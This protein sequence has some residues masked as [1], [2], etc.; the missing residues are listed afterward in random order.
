MEFL[1]LEI[2]SWADIAAA[3]GTIGAVWI[4]LLLSRADR[5]LH[6]EDKQIEDLNVMY[7]LIL[8]MN[9]LSDLI[10]QAKAHFEF[11]DS[12]GMGTTSSNDKA[13]LHLMRRI[14]REKVENILDL[15]KNLDD[16]DVV[17]DL[18]SDTRYTKKIKNNIF[19]LK[20]LFF[21]FHIALDNVQEL[22]KSGM[23]PDDDEDFQYILLLTKI[24]DTYKELKKE[25]AEEVKRIKKTGV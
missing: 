17:K 9:S 7:R 15:E 22:E 11:Y 6:F 8:K 12:D 24:D 23:N 13:R 2:G 20:K 18:L 1:G 19:E 3:F 16:L 25:I 4:A 5:R 10:P 21:M 14:N